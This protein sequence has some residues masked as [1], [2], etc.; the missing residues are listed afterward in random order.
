MDI[1]VEELKRRLDEGEDLHFYD[2]R[3]EHEYEEDNLG[4]TLIPLGELPDHLDELEPLKGE[5]III[6]CR[7]GARSGKA[8]KFLE[9]QG[10]SNVRNVLGGIL[11][12]RELED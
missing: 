6:H 7:S 8:A 12:Y 1:T 9:S 5:E 3:E 11:A 4:A 2:V 10:F